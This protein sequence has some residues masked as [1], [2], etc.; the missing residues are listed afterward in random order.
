MNMNDFG[1]SVISVFAVGF[2]SVCCRFKTDSGFLE[3]QL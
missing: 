3:A 1:Q 2:F